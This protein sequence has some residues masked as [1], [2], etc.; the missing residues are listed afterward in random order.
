MKIRLAAAGMAMLPALAGCIPNQQY[1]GP[2]AVDAAAPPPRDRY[3]DDRYREPPSYEP[4]PPPQRPP[5]EVRPVVPEAT[6]VTEGD[7]I[8]QPGDTLRGI[9][10]RTGAGSEAIARVNGLTAPFTIV[11]GQRLRIPGGRYHLVHPGETG[12]AIA[13][14]YRVPWSR[15]VD[16][17]DLTE[18]YTLRAGQRILIP[19]GDAPVDRYAGTAASRPANRDE[20]GLVIDDIVT[21]GEPALADNGRA[22]RPSTSTATLP[23]PDTPIAAPSHFSGSFAWPVNG[24]VVRRFGPGATG[25]RNDGI[26]IA[27][28]IDTPVKA[29]ADGV[30][31]YTGEGVAGL[32][33]LVILKHGDGWVSVYG[34]ADKVMVQRGQQVRRGQTIAL[35]GDSGFADRPEVH[36]ELRKG[37][38]PVDPLA[39]LPAR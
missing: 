33:G 38:T 37:R 22:A 15:I 21:G 36:F 16:A 19:E 32:G 5:W 23:P 4:P 14:A 30:V 6:T 11:V 12:I 34:H 39:E 29:S 27:V 3:D 17:N 13:Q 9:A 8:V 20:L 35:S 24:T 31:A 1:D 25:V 7:Y 2:P 28:P 10:G 26:K 18:P